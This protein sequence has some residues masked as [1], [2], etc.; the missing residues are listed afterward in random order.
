MR[1][2]SGQAAL[3]L[4]YLQ[5]AG[6]SASTSSPP[7]PASP[8]LRRATRPSARRTERVGLFEARRTIRREPLPE[9]GHV[10]RGRWLLRQHVRRLERH[11]GARVQP[12]V[13]TALGVV[14]GRG[15][16]LAPIQLRLGREALHDH[17]LAHELF[18]WRCLLEVD[19][20][21]LQ[22]LRS[23]DLL[24]TGST[25]LRLLHRL[26]SSRHRVH[27]RRG[28]ATHGGSERVDAPTVCS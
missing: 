1:C 25:H 19:L 28:V 4:R 24:M 27:L 3:R 8:C 2:A 16:A 15:D 23:L 18:I 11:L 13:V 9:L 6:G 10:R 5:H 17:T 14:E 21:G 26:L 20:V 7:Y 12:D 22:F